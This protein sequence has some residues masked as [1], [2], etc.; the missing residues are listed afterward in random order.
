MTESCGAAAAAAAATSVF[1]N[2][3]WSFVKLMQLILKSFAGLHRRLDFTLLQKRIFGS[4][5]VG[6]DRG[7]TE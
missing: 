1:K 5:W 6:K 7:V 2:A 3:L 4:V